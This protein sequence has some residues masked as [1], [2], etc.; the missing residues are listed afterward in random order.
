MQLGDIATTIVM[1]THLVID[2]VEEISNISV[3]S[4]PYL[5]HILVK[6]WMQGDRAITCHPALQACLQ[7]TMLIT[8]TLTTP[9]TLTFNEGFV[10]DGDLLL[11]GNRRAMLSFISDGEILQELMRN[12]R[13]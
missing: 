1:D 13:G 10:T 6:I 3:H 2:M 9:L 8:N 12:V 5:N 4:M 7:A 11:L